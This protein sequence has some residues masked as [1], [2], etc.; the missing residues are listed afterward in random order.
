MKTHNLILIGILGA[1]FAAATAEAQP[2][3]PRG[4]GHGQNPGWGQRFAGRGMALQ[5]LPPDV[6][7]KLKT[8]VTKAKE[9]PA[10]KAAREK[11]RGGDRKAAIGEFRK[12]FRDAIVKADPSLEEPL[13]KAGPM[14]RRQFQNRR[15]WAQ[16]PPMPQQPAP[17]LRG[18]QGFQN[19]R[20]WA[21][22]PQGANPQ[23]GRGQPG[24]NCPRGFCPPQQEG[25]GYGRGRQNQAPPMPPPN[26][27]WQQRGPQGRGPGWGPP[28]HRGGPP[29]QGPNFQ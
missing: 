13:K 9:D 27:G 19:R 21:Q 20:G 11:L 5:G 3:G 4:W 12:A 28:P 14:M 24:P 1:G 6:R 8:A 29:W 15:G 16:A 25:R 2:F 18:G 23:W 17:R 10:V 22:P 7:E 26:Q